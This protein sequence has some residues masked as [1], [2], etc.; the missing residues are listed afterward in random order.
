M[1]LLLPC[2]DLT[3]HCLQILFTQSS[4]FSQ[5][6]KYTTPYYYTKDGQIRKLRTLRQGG[7]VKKCGRDLVALLSSIHCLGFALLWWTRTQ[8]SYL[9]MLQVIFGIHQDSCLFGGVLQCPCCL[10][11]KVL[12]DDSLGN[13]Q[14]WSGNCIN[15][16]TTIP[17]CWPIVGGKWMASSSDLR[18]LAQATST[19]HGLFNGWTYDQPLWCIFFVSL[20]FIHQMVRFEHATILKH[21]APFMIQLWL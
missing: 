6:N 4:R 17:L 8:G 19:K 1:T 20:A 16:C 21:L 10:L 9:V 15:A 3:R 2:V 12:R 18:D 13:P 5:F 14:L 11:V 7:V